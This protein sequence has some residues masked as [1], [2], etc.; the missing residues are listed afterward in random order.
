V[1]PKKFEISKEKLIELIN[2]YPYQK[3]AKMYN[4]SD[5]AIKKRM[6]KYE[7]K[8]ENKIG[9]WQKLNSQKINKYCACGNEIKKKTS[10]I[11]VKC[12]RRKNLK[13]YKK[14]I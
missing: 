10:Q 12:S 3:I 8:A 5:N 7:I 13:Y 2:I 9:Y 6:I 4:V 11:C 14:Q 1:S